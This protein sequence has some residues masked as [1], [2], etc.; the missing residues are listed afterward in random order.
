MPAQVGIQWCGRARVGMPGCATLAGLLAGSLLCIASIGDAG[1]FAR[2][3]GS[4]QVELT[5]RPADLGGLDPLVL[6]GDDGSIV[7]ACLFEGLTRWGDGRIEP[8]LA[9]TW[10]R[11]ADDTRW[12]FQLRPEARFH[13]GARCDA[14][15]VS[16]SLHRLA[17]SRQS[18]HAWL[19][20]DLVGLEDFVAGETQQIEGIYV[21]SATE[22]ELH[23][24][25][26]VKDVAARLAL[27]EA[28][29]TRR[30]DSGTTGTGP[31]RVAA[32]APETL[33]CA[34]FEPHHA[35]R[36]FLAALTVLAEQ[37][38][39]PR[40]RDALTIH[41]LDPAA[42]PAAGAVRL[43]SPARRLALA[44]IHPAS[45]AFAAA[46]ARARLAAGFD[47]AVFV[48]AGLAGDGEPALGLYPDAATLRSTDAL[49]DDESAKEPARRAVKILVPAADPVLHKLGERL[50]VQLS[51]L[52][53]EVELEDRPPATY[54]A[55]LRGGRYDI[56]VL[57][58]TPP[59]DPPDALQESSRVLHTLGTLLAPVL[60][61]ALPPAWRDLLAG[62]VHATEAALMA[63]G[64]L[65]PLVFFHEAW[66]VPDVAQS[67][68]AAAG[69][70]RH[71][72]ADV[73]LQPSSP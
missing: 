29:I 14:Q 51:Q 36:P 65:L 17:N 59:Q 63:S 53:Y 50:Q 57:G 72:L 52:S 68:R 41:R 35:G 27:P 21:L 28:G 16:E 71:G 61:E 9:E 32:A 10:V 55:A 15:S 48:R 24:A 56:A 70:A 11:S 3:G 54:A 2:Y 64:H 60:G 34:A 4:V 37:P 7:A 31:F 66:E 13:D 12:L 39:A 58:W 20:R 30:Q 44:L 5:M 62:R 43:R 46:P 1:R 8:G 69:A 47:A 38:G 67:L 6:W 19:L 25:R 45:A 73:H 23:F 26:P 18:S 33:R 42:R 40:A 49:P 22:I